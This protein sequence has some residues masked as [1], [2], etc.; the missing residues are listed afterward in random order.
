MPQEPNITTNDNEVQMHIEDFIQA[1]IQEG[2]HSPT[3]RT[4]T[5]D[6]IQ[7]NNHTLACFHM[8]CALLSCAAAFF[9]FARNRGSIWLNMLGV[10][11][12]CL[13][14]IECCNKDASL[15]GKIKFRIVEGTIRIEFF[16]TEKTFPKSMFGEDFDMR[17][18]YK[19]IKIRKFGNSKALILY[20][21]DLYMKKLRF[22]GKTQKFCFQDLTQFRY[23]FHI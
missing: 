23:D 19:S 15:I 18:V 20:R 13:I 9:V 4:F 6:V 17:K 5:Y 22:V 8:L 2:M 10:F 12:V 16:D 1:N 7:M 11:L 21:S 3:S 14:P